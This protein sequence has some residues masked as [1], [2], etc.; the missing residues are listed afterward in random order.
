MK[1]VLIVL[2]DAILMSVFKSWVFRSQK[3]EQLFFAK[4]G[5]EAIEII[6]I[7]AIDLVIMELSLAEIDGLELATSLALYYST[8]KIAFFLSA[9]SLASSEKLKK[10][11]SVYFIN[12]PNSLREFIHL[13]S[14]IEVAGSQ[15]LPLTAI[16]IADFLELVEFQK[17]TCL[18]AIENTLNQEKGL[19]YFEHGVLYDAVYANFKAEQ[20]VVE[21]LNWPQVKIVFKA[22]AKK[23]FRRQVQSSLTSLI[24]ERANLTTYQTA[25]LERTDVLM[26]LA[27]IPEIVLDIT[28]PAET[29]ALIAQAEVE[30]ERR[31]AQ[32]E[33]EEEKLKVQAQVETEIEE[34]K[35]KAQV[36]A[37]EEKLKAQA[38]VEAKKAQLEAW[39]A[40][41]SAVNLTE[42]LKPLQEMDDYLASAIFDI[43]GRIVI[44]NNM[45]TSAHNVEEI[46]VNAV[47]MIKTAVETVSNAGL[48][49]FNFIQVTADE[50]I[51]EAVWV[52]EGQFIAA[53]LL[54]PAA[55]N[56]GLAK[57]RL[58]KVAN[59]VHSQLYLV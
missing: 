29:V 59:F 49:T 14:V 42:V 38:E 34:E 26:P 37:E 16:A 6:K 51:F 8:V 30:E 52:V 44:K 40:K 41:I 33:A 39:L 23:Q 17:K 45:P 10:L 1:K 43:T 22:L 48:G 31:K 32:V 19:I 4:D 12:K 7:Q 3:K 24:K 47:M 58:I 5:K 9:T 50:G 13:V 46:S 18:L 21:M 20:A 25:V 36:E 35:G 54:N 27:P 2:N 56:T 53:V 57:M 15:A 55:K 28:P 11:T